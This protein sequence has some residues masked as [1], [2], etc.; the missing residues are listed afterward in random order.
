MK[1]KYARDNEMSDVLAKNIKYFRKEKRLRQSDIGEACG[2]ESA[3]A[4]SSLGYRIELGSQMNVAENL[5]VIQLYHICEL[6]DVS[7]ADLF[8]GYDGTIDI[9]R[10]PKREKEIIDLLKGLSDE[11]YEKVRSYIKDLSGNPKYQN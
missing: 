6:L 10:S 3:Q 7:M 4:K 11:G 9:A 2:L 5:R 1:R 8:E